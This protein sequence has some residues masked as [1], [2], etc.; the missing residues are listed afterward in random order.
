MKK[1][2][3]SITQALLLFL[4]LF[5]ITSLPHS[6][7]PQEFIA[8]TLYAAWTGLIGF[9]IFKT[10]KISRYRSIFFI[11]AT[12]GFLL[13]FKLGLLSLPVITDS[14]AYQP[15]S[16]QVA[17][18]APFCHIAMPA[19]MGMTLSNVLNAVFSSPR[20]LRLYI[21]IFL[22]L[23]VT[24]LA[25]QA[26]CSWVCFYGGIDEWFSS[27]LKKPIFKLTN[28]SRRVKN[29]SLG[30]LFFLILA[31][32]STNTPVFCKWLCPLKMSTA[33]M[34]SYA[35]LRI[36][37]FSLFIFVTAVFLVIGP[38]VTKKRTFC[39]ILCPFGAWQSVAGQLNPY[40]VT[41]DKEKCVDCK[42]CVSACPNFSL[43]EE[44][45]KSREISSYCVRCANCIDVCP[46]NAIRF[47]ALQK[48]IN[49]RYFNL[50]DIFVFSM[51]LLA[52]TVTSFFAPAGFL[53]AL[54][55]CLRIILKIS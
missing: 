55:E 29:F 34:D 12:V 39:A 6:A 15:A 32:F 16:Q 41:I 10:G 48:D 53:K 22:W 40:R 49:N 28:V 25:G 42:K 13:A 27:L 36:A 47:T 45:L 26:W 24:L 14:A 21:F 18:E 35:P 33:F 20:Y 30:L 31:S 4:L 43:T 44:N 54:S 5:L 1:I 9:L 7:K 38:I 17:P 50:Q 11:T 52:G 37:Q 51:L 46:T 23:G 8:R 2:I 19:N 3:A